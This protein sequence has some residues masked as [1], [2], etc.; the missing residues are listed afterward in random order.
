MTGG[1]GRIAALSDRSGSA[2]IV[3]MDAF[4]C[5]VLELLVRLVPSVAQLHAHSPPLFST[6][7]LL[8]P[9]AGGV[10]ST[11]D[12]FAVALLC[13]PFN[14]FFFYTAVVTVPVFGGRLGDFAGVCT[15]CT[16]H[17][18][19]LPLSSPASLPLQHTIALS[20]S[21][22]PPPPASL[23]RSAWRI[24]MRTA[25][26]HVLSHMRTCIENVNNLREVCEY[27][28]GSFG[29]CVPRLSP[30]HHHSPPAPHPIFLSAS[31]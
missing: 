24:G 18:C 20:R 7:Y 16:L 12:V 19:M 31:Q 28:G 27:C 15:H 30:P 29:A 4:T 5:D 21:S 8:L 1:G 3:S 17:C 2:L 10:P 22:S 25:A 23:R 13:L 26:V 14:W 9:Q 6:R 11:G